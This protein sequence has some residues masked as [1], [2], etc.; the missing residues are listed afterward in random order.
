MKADI[1]KWAVIVSHINKHHADVTKAFMDSGQKK[2]RI[3]LCS[4]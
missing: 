4:N 1:T 2:E 3:K